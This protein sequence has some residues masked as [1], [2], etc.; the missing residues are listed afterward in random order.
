MLA[1]A[2]LEGGMRVAGFVVRSAQDRDNARRLRQQHQFRI[3]CLGESTTAGEAGIPRYP[4]AL[5]KILN[6]QNLGVSVVAINMGRSG[7]VTSELVEQLETEIEAFKPN[8]VVAMMGINDGGKTHAY[9]TIIEPGRGNWYGTFRLYKLYRLIRHKLSTSGRRTSTDA[10]TTLGEGIPQTTPTIDGAYVRPGPTP[11]EPTPRIPDDTEFLLGVRRLINNGELGAARRLLEE[12]VANDPGFDDGYIELARISELL[13]DRGGAH[14]ILLDGAATLPT[15]SILLQ[16]ELAASFDALG[17]TDRAIE[18]VTTIRREL[19]QPSN[20]G[21]HTHQAGVLADLY[22]KSGQIEAAEATRKEIAE[23]INPGHP[24]FYDELI[25]FYERHDCLDDAR[26][27][28]EIRRRV[29]YEYV[30]PETRRN[31]RV[32]LEVLRSRGI[33]LYAVQYPGRDVDEV[34]RLLGRSPW[35]VFV[36][37]SFF[38]PL[39]EKD[40]FDTYYSDDFAGDFGH[41]TE[42]GNYLLAENIARKIAEHSFE[43][44]LA[45]VP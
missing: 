6:R 1:L 3:L 22:E 28:R 15:P 41:L 40:G 16:S 8:I 23:K 4:E 14:Q 21:D 7:A 13:G 31:Y 38:Q 17:E 34:E 32:L 26:I 18:I 33:Q 5:Q 27:Y 20:L 19:L 44:E 43:R 30:N 12:R 25:A 2:A 10:S 45:D 39:V 36:D 35:P 42:L 24:R 9:G 37:N 11:P 29:R